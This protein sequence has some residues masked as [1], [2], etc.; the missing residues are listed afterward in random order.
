MSAVGRDLR[1]AVR[2]LLKHRAF[3]LM[4]IVTLGLGIGAAT[5]IFSVIQNVLL[6]P[7]P[8]AHTDRNVSLVIWD[9]SRPRNGDRVFFRVGEFLEYQGQMSSFEEVI[10]AGSRTF[11][12]RPARAPSSSRARS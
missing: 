10:G 1:Y 2:S 11:C 3:T 8:Y 9:T 4:A 7:Y 5:A 6:D 12:T